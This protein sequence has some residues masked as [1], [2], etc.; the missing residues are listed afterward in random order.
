MHATLQPHQILRMPALMIDPRHIWNIIY[1]ARSNRCHHPTPP[2]IAPTTKKDI[3]R[4]QETVLKTETSPNTA[5]ATKSNTL[6]PPNSA[7]S[8]QSHSTMSDTQ[9][10]TSL[11][12]QQV[13]PS[14]LPNITPATKHDP[15]DWSFA[16]RQTTLSPLYEMLEGN[17]TKSQ[18]SSS[19]SA[20]IKAVDASDVINHKSHSEANAKTRLK[21]SS[22]EVGAYIPDLNALSA[23]E[24]KSRTTKRHLA[25]DGVFWVKTHRL[26]SILAPF[27][28]EI[29]CASLS[30]MFLPTFK[31][32]S[33]FTSV[34]IPSITCSWFKRKPVNSSLT[35][36]GTSTSILIPPNISENT[37]PFEP[38]SMQDS[39]DANS[40]QTSWWYQWMQW[41]R[42]SIIPRSISSSSSSPLKSTSMV[43]SS[44]KFP[45]AGASSAPAGTLSRRD[46]A[47]KAGM[48]SRTPSSTWGSPSK[49]SLGSTKGGATFGSLGFTPLNN[50]QTSVHG[51]LPVD[52]WHLDSMEMLKPHL[53]WHTSFQD[54][55]STP[56]YDL[57]MDPKE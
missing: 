38:T 17:K 33:C 8:T 4:H 37:V 7:P 26:V 49:T 46:G 30:V 56:F 35:S 51:S 42:R 27:S 10:E 45:A 14:N 3:P 11:T 22:D 6:T 5:P 57:S 21:E 53:Q 13:W 20:Y 12:E 24:A 40:F 34:F 16:P 54:T 55:F 36:S 44:S 29:F 32:S 23:P 9:Y 47:G 15:H 2:N 50:G 31:V 41:S 25:K 1:I 43:S 39:W 48:S 19:T 18:A 28:R 52:H